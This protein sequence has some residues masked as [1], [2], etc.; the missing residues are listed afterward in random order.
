VNILFVG[1]VV[2]EPGRRAIA[3][4]VGVLRSEGKIDFCIANAE[5][6]A[7]GFGLT[8]EVA[9]ELLLVSR[10]LEQAKGV[11]VESVRGVAASRIARGVATRHGA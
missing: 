4:H 10:W 9:D 3:A 11:R 8:R 1:D 5:N 6:A 2:G 7:G